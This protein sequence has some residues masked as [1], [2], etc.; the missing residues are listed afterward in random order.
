MT[1][2]EH[3]SAVY[4]NRC[5]ENEGFSRFVSL[6]SKEY[7]RVLDV[8]C[9]NGA[10]LK[11]L[12]DRGHR[13]EGLTI[14]QMEAAF[15][16]K[17]GFPVKVWDITRPELPYPPVSF[18]ALL[19][20]HVLEH[21]TWPQQVLENY[22]CMLRPG[23]GVYIALPNSLH[24]VQRLQFLRGH[25]RYTDTG[26]MD[27]THLRFFDFVTARQLVESCG[28]K[29][30]RH[31]GIGQCPVGPLREWMPGLS[32][33]IDQWTTNFWPSLFAVHLIVIAL[34]VDK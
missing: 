4:Q 27:R 12:L 32:H 13:A 21:V 3:I 24:L 9:G 22:L 15:V 11:L 19:F 16:E 20:S 5:Y 34:F 18:D 33:R 7:K 1:S 17:R 28:L 29:V 25:F 31:F 26:V 2:Q 30:V 8:G 10:N 14:S 23:G 6:V